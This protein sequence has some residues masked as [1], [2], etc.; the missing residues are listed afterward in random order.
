MYFLNTKASELRPGASKRKGYEYNY[1][2]PLGPSRENIE[3]QQMKVQ[4]IVKTFSN[5]NSMHK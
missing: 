2:L 4:G 5:D 3:I 1:V